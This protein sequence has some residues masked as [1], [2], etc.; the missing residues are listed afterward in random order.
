MSA[1]PLGSRPQTHYVETPLGF[2]AYQVFGAGERD[3]M[4]INGGISNID[5]VWDE[6]SAVRFYDRLASLGR[7]IQYDMRGSGVSD[8]IPGN[9]TWLPLEGNMDDVRAVMD[10]AGSDRAV[11]Y[12]DTEG[13]L[14]AMMLAATH[15]ERV[16]ALILVNAVPRILRADDYPIGAPQDVADSLSEQ[17]IAQHGTTGD[18]LRLRLQA[19]PSTHGFGRGLRGI[20]FWLTRTGWSNARSSGSTR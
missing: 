1:L 11:V 12:G 2:L 5:A 16:S 8:P 9:N 4:F 19:S 6:P 10:A 7:V 15:P 3:V 18:L 17:Y 20:S 14:S 13:G